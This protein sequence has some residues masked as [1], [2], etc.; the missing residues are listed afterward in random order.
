M[1]TFL[2]ATI[3]ITAIILTFII[4]MQP[5]KDGGLGGLS[6][7]GVTDSVFGTGRNEFLTKLTWVLMI[8]FLSA[9]LG[10][11]KSITEANSAK[12]EAMAVKS[13][14]EITETAPVKTPEIPKSLTE[15]PEK[16]EVPVKTEENK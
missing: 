3:V 14:G 9:S 1:D 13:A 8:V 16:A 12:E 11:A 2:T 10:L 6:S 7:G 4:I 15:M 5:S